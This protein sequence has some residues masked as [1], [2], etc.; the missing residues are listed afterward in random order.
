MA[1]IVDE[2]PWTARLRM[3]QEC[4][5]P[6]P[7]MQPSVRGPHLSFSNPS[8][9][10]A[11]FQQIAHSMGQAYGVD[12]SVLEATHN[13]PFPPTLNAEATLQGRH[14]HFAPGLDTDDNIRHEVGHAIDNTVNGPPLGHRRRDGL[15]IDTSREQT[16]DRWTK[17]RPVHPNPPQNAKAIRPLRPSAAIQR[18]VA[19]NEEDLNQAAVDEPLRY[20]MDNAHNNWFDV[21]EQFRRQKLRYD[22]RDEGR[23]GTTHGMNRLL[24]TRVEITQDLIDTAK[25]PTKEAERKNRL[26]FLNAQADLETLDPPDGFLDDIRP[27]DGKPPGSTGPTSDIDVN[28]RGDGTEFAV[29]FIND[30]FRKRYGNQQESGVVYDI[31]FYAKDFVPDRLGQ[32]KNDNQLDRQD[33]EVV[34]PFVLAKGDYFDKDDEWR[35]HVFQNPLIQ[36]VDEIEQQTSARLMLRKNI[37]AERWQQYTAL[38]DVEDKALVEHRLAERERGAG[39]SESTNNALPEHLRKIAP[40][41]RAY[42]RILKEEVL[43]ARLAYRYFRFKVLTHPTDKKLAARADAAYQKLKAAKSKALAYANEA[44]YTQGAVIGVVVNMQ[45][46]DTT[47]KNAP[48]KRFRKLQLTPAEY[49]HGFTEQTGFAIHSLDHATHLDD[50]IR[51]GKYINRAY[52]LFYN[53]SVVSGQPGPR[54]KDRRLARAWEGNKKGVEFL[55]GKAVPINDNKEAL[56]MELLTSYIG[57]E[58]TWR[59]GDDEATYVG[60]VV[61]PIVAKLLFLQRGFDLTWKAY[62]DAAPAH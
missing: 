11:R 7:T 40:E 14:I 47:F 38:S 33:N 12:T 37:S 6:I 28:L 34:E 4:I 62:R 19:R 26:A 58:A 54:Q 22:K 31:N 45:I 36:L 35:N 13:S 60:R 10:S 52:D 44:Y 59:E 56:F 55:Y 9:G 50:L 39:S 42:E 18:R 15:L 41:N 24:R 46:L 61:D 29:E 16:V 53:F 30:D 23:E 48:K 8:K 25:A 32:L 49:Y 57:T 17:E 27:L 2:R 20:T 43:P 3:L 21:I 5:K 51:V 1:T